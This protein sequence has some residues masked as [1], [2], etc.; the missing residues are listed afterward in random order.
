MMGLPIQ[1]AC[2]CAH[3]NPADSGRPAKSHRSAACGALSWHSEKPFPFPIPIPNQDM[4][5]DMDMDIA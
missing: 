5:M 2:S 3:G 1:N 4:D